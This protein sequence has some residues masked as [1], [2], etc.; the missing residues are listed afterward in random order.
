MF[1][2]EEIEGRTAVTLMSKPVSRRQFLLGKFVGILLGIMLMFGL[3]GV[4]FE[5][6]MIYKA[7][8]DRVEWFDYINP[9]PTTVPWVT[10]LLGKMALSGPS[11][12]ILRGLGFWANLTFQ[13]LPGL[14]LSFFLVIVLVA[15]AVA[16]A[17]RVPMVVNLCAVLAVYFLANL[18]PVLVSVSEKARHQADSGAVARS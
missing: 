12:D 8:L 18:S 15:L 1:V 5:G 7:W 9:T 16:L 10:T 11:L 14:I 6:I 3:L 4:W 13:S 2:S 17:T